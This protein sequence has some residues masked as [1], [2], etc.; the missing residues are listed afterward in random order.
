VLNLYTLDLG[1]EPSEDVIAEA[2]RKFYENNDAGKS[3][4]DNP[5]PS[6]IDAAGHRRYC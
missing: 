1:K 2:V 3:G 5:I 4:A 6:F